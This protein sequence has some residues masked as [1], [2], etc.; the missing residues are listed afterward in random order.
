MVSLDLILWLLAGLPVG[1]ALGLTGG[2]GSLLAV[3]LL[4]YA[5]GLAPSRAV[6]LRVSTVT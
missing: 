5:F 3:P 6:P 1:L 2:G 4:I